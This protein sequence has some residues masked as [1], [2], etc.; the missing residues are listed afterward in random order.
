MQKGNQ[1]EA[2]LPVRTAGELTL[3]DGSRVWVK[4]LNALQRAEAQSRAELYAIC[5]ARPWRRGGAGRQA[6]LEEF[7]EWDTA[8]LADYLAATGDLDGTYEEQALQVVPDPPRPEREGQNE[9][10]YLGQLET[11]ETA[12]GIAVVARRERVE[13]LR[14]EAREAVLAL[15]VAE[16]VEAC[17]QEHWRRTYRAFFGTRMLVETLF[18]AVRRPEERGRPHFATRDEVE[19][20]SDADRERL[21]SFYLELD[22]VRPAEVPTMPPGS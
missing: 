12:C 15:S 18:R 6:A 21:L 20:L 1:M 9:A 10:A 8:R 16:R 5:E 17:A 3:A 22:C 11:W 14:R 19:D 2:T 4:T 7:A 13:R